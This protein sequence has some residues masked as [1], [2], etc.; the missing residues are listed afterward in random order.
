MKGAKHQSVPTHVISALERS[1]GDGLVYDVSWM[2]GF[3]AVPG[4]IPMSSINTALADCG[5]HVYSMDVASGIP[6]ILVNR[7]LPSTILDLCCCPGGKLLYAVDLMDKTGIVMGVDISER[8]LETCRSLVQ[9]YLRTSQE[10]ARIFLFCSNGVTF[11]SENCDRLYF[12]SAINSEQADKQSTQRKRRNKSTRAREAKRLRTVQ[13]MFQRNSQ[14]DNYACDLA[15]PLK[16]SSACSVNDT[17]NAADHLECSA[18]DVVDN[19]ADSSAD[20]KITNPFSLDAFDAVIVDAQCTHDGSYRH[21]RFLDGLGACQGGRVDSRDG[22]VAA[23]AEGDVEGE[24]A[25][26]VLSTLPLRQVSKPSIYRYIGHHSSTGMISEGGNGG[27][28]ASTHGS[29]TRGRLLAETSLDEALPNEGDS[30]ED[31]SLRD[32]QRGLILNGFNRLRVGGTMVYSTCSMRITQN[33]DIVQWLVDTVGTDRVEMLSLHEMCTH[34]GTV[35]L[36][37]PNSSYHAATASVLEGSD[38]EVFSCLHDLFVNHPDS[39]RRLACDICRY[40][41]TL[42]KPPGRPGVIEGSAYFGR[43]GGMSGLFVAHIKKK[44]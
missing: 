10:N 20:N 42:P 41:A 28:V 34:D 14:H 26:D 9:K 19:I 1:L 2:P 21:L 7:D 40:V 36:N 38:D 22:E 29:E 6:P 13:N 30:L 37:A 39:F 8:R 27:G 18:V 4:F 3:I 25:G 17:Q 15:V 43:W 24:Q 31:H 35:L 32:L 12:D 33:E 44:M 16:V 5:S 23:T 11:S